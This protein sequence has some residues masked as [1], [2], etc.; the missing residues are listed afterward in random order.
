MCDVVCSERVVFMRNET[1]CFTGHRQIPPGERT[2]IANR[3][4]CAITDLYQK[5]IR[6]YGAG[7]ALG[8]DA[9]AA[10]T[11]IRLR[12]S[13]PGMRLIL[14]LPCLTQT[15]GWRPEDIAEYERI[16]SQADKRAIMINDN[17]SVSLKDMLAT[18][19][20]YHQNDIPVTKA[21]GVVDGNI[22]EVPLDAKPALLSGTVTVKECLHTGEGV[23]TY[24]HTEGTTT[25]RQTCLACGNK[26]DEENCSFGENGK[27]ACEAVLAVALKD[28]TEL[29]YTGAAQTPEVNVTVDGQT[30]AT[31]K[32][33]LSY[34]NNINAGNTAKVTVT[35]TSFTGTFTLPFTI[36]P[37]TP[38]LAWEST[39]QELTYTGNEAMITAPKAT[40]VN[41]IQLGITHD[42][43]PC[44]FS[45]AK[46]GDSEFTNGLPINAGTYTIKASIAAKGNYAAA[47]S[48]NTL[49]L[50]I[51][52]SQPTIAFV[53][54]YD[55]SKTYDGQTI[56]NPTA[57]DLTITGA[58]YGNVAFTWYKGSVAEANKLN[59]APKDAGTYILTANIPETTNTAVASTD[60]LTVTISKAPLTV[61]GATIQTRPYK[62][63][64]HTAEVSGVT[65]TGLVNGETL[66]LGEDYA[67][68]GNY[69]DPNAGENKSATILVELKSSAKANNYTLPKD[70]SV[71]AT[72]TITKASQTTPQISGLPSGTIHLRRYLCPER[73]KRCNMV[74]QRHRRCGQFRQGHCHWHR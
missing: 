3:L 35:G 1:C 29:T 4:E 49:T 73:R 24:T 34:D 12:E 28:N 61:T 68:F 53:N 15:R 70:S 48:T 43:G 62:P 69:D 37:A 10:Q 22:G 14:V 40:G 5:G 55:P 72:G 41:G 11:V 52:K 51:N 45:Y 47:D 66:A 50:T 20:A 42:T 56:P 32:Y 21:E 71:N 13:C 46:Q 44:Q 30:L 19:Y 8:F 31:E 26:W 9:L 58:S 25:H 39:T 59:V 64:Y 6:Y 27:C 38:T 18:G 54:S 57:D 17:A 2:E 74:R 36:N 7:G 33:Q 63:T 65:F 60:P 16:K 67:A 23:C